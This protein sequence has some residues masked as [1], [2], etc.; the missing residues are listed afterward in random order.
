MV[1]VIC[2][3]CFHIFVDRHLNIILCFFFA[4]NMIMNKEKNNHTNTHICV[5]SDV[6][7]HV[8]CVIEILNLGFKSLQKYMNDTERL[9][10]ATRV[11]IACSLRCCH[12]H[13]K[14]GSH[15]K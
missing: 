6:M 9:N 3:C 12:I 7:W 4:I 15:A 2:G 10:N 8:S 13:F 14:H 11:Y 1:K 5:S